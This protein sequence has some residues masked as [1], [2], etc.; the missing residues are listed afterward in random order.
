MSA[1]LA[2]VN[3]DDTPIAREQFLDAFG[4]MSMYGPDQSSTW[5][6][7]AV[8]LGQHML[9]VTPESHFDHQPY[10]W[11]EAVIVADARIDNRKELCDLFQLSVEERLTTPDSHLILRSYRRW[12]EKCTSKLLGDY[13]FVVWDTRERQLFCARDHIG[14]RPL[15]YYYSSNV[16]IVATDL[17]AL[18]AFSDIHYELDVREVATYLR[19][20]LVTKRKT[21]FKQFHILEPRHQ[22]TV[23]KENLAY[24]SHWFP[25]N[26][27]DVKYKRISEYKDHLRWL[28]ES[29][30]EARTNTPYPVAAHVS[31]GL[32]SSSVA[33]IANRQLRKKGRSLRAL[34]TWTPS[35][36]ESY[37]FVENDERLRI[38]ALSEQEQ[39]PVSYGTAT[40]R[41]FREFLARDVALEGTSDLYEELPL[42]EHA[43]KQGIRVIVSGWGGDEAATYVGRGYL[44]YLL[45]TGRLIKLGRI[46]HKSVGI[47]KLRKA[48]S[49][50]FHNAFVP[51]LPNSLY[52]HFDPYSHMVDLDQFISPALDTKYIS[53]LRRPIEYWRE[54]SDPRQIQIRGLTNGHLA[55]RMAAWSVWSSV[56][57]VVHTYPMTDRR[58]LEFVLGLPRDLLFHKEQWRYLY[59]E[60]VKDLLPFSP[61]VTDPVNEQKRL[62]HRVDCW[63]LLALEAENGKWSTDDVPWLDIDKLSL[64]LRDV[65]QDISRDH[66]LKFAALRPPIRIWHLWRR[67]G[68]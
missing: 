9:H 57:S 42:L 58:I 55:N 68:N 41:H 49:F 65:P 66:V 59:Y 35:V 62:K 14:T 29:S 46:I 1:I 26:V 16:L 21:F 18:Q 28:V 23:G 8:G 44:P 54:L 63:S 10:V 67:Y 53:N 25:E 38:D 17:R 37:P 2:R 36:S 45:K 27:P 64:H 34:Y 33:A 12:K 50:L 51:L 5:F 19:W 4:T 52:S 32:D 15:Y 61:A 40:G 3:F 60:S 22:L 7:G 30:V 20:P 39:V 11:D 43:G 56:H 47:R 13:T 31:G 6:E 24:H 48:F